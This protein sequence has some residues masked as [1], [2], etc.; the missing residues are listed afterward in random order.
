MTKQIDLK[1]CPFCGNAGYSQKHAE[2]NS[3]MAGCSD[4][5]CIAH[6]VAYDFVSEETAISAWNTRAS[7][8]PSG[9][10]WVVVPREPTGEMI[11]AMNE[12][13]RSQRRGGAGGMSIEAQWRREYA[14]ELAAYR[15]MIAA[16]NFI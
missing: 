14:P 8:S 6:T 7:P 10:E 13:F 9:G 1:P 5:D 12:G 15:A 3:F 16:F 11:E 4:A 2:Y